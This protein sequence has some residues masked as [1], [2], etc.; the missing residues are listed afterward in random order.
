MECPNCKEHYVFKDV[1]LENRDLKFL[2][3]EFTCPFCEVLITPNKPYKITL[4]ILLVLM[5]ISTLL[6]F[7][8][9]IHPNALWL[10]MSLGLV[11]FF[12]LLLLRLIL[13]YEIKE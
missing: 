4:S 12:L 8:E 3:T 11:S 9:G 7:S 5:A 10:G 2:I 13:K 1:P 6:I